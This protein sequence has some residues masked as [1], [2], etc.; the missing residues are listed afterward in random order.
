MEFGVLCILKW[1]QLLCM[2]SVSNADLCHYLNVHSCSYLVCKCRSKILGLFLVC[3]S[4]LYHIWLIYSYIYLD[5]LN[6]LLLLQWQFM[7][8]FKQLTWT[9]LRLWFLFRCRPH[10]QKVGIYCLWKYWTSAGNPGQHQSSV[11][12]D[13]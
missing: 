3:I 10:K 13:R 7:F 5:G 6:T 2:F 9:D 8:V 1:T 12:P 4:F 11:E